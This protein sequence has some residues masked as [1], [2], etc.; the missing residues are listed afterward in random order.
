MKLVNFATSA[1]LVLVLS[2]CGTAEYRAEKSSCE[3]E[4]M[5]KIPPR[6]EQEIYNKTET[7]QVPTGEI[8]CFGTY[9][10]TCDQ[11][12]RTEY[13]TVPAV[14]TVDRNE[15]RRDA[16]SKICTRQACVRKYGNA[17]CEVG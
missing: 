2:A 3:V 6:Y 1:C 14:R 15:A 16:Q 7:R 9:I 17:E 4:W 10:I 5:S 11:T 12:M 13:Y 8:T